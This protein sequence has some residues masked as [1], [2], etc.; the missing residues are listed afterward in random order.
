MNAKLVV[1]SGKSAGRAISL[2]NGRILIGRA[3]ECDVRPLG[4]EVSRRHCL[5][6]VEGEAVT[7]EDLKSRNGTYVNGERIPAKTTVKNG[8]IVRVGPLE[9]KVSLPLPAAAPADRAA[10][11]V[12]DVSRWLMADDEP[13]GMFDT[14]QTVRVPDAA[15]AEPPVAEPVAQ[16]GAAAGSREADGSSLVRAKAGE[17]GAPVAGAGPAGSD[18]SASVATS[19][20]AIEALLATR[21]QPGVL[22]EAARNAA[23]SNNSK[24]AAAEALRKFFGK[25]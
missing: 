16:E 10:A 20:S 18:S 9:L 8:D 3:E 17:Q 5:I 6:L 11:A 14:T 12:D 24:E 1:A 4:E 19:G 21:A 22:P 25:R 13:V 15:P 23:K 7:V 2:K